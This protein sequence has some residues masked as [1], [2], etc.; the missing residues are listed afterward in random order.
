VQEDLFDVDQPAATAEPILMALHAEYYDLI[1]AGLKDHEFRKRFLRDQP[2]RWFVYLNTPAASP[3]SPTSPNGC[4]PATET[5]CT[6]ISGTWTK[7]SLPIQAIREYPGMAVAGRW[8]GVVAAHSLSLS[9]CSGSL[10]VLSL[11]AP[12]RH[13]RKGG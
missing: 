12:W 2:T 11:G 6:P 3:T 5:A 1:W 9:C 10:G 8:D 7:D 13:E 4:G